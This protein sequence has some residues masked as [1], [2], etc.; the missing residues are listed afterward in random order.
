MNRQRWSLGLI[1][2]GYLAITLAYGAVNPLFEAPD[3]QWH[4]FTAD[5]IASN[6]RLPVVGPDTQQWLGQEAAQPPLYYLL[7]AQLIK[8]IDTAGAADSLWLNPY[9]WI[10][11]A[12]AL[13]NVNRMVHTS[14]E[15]WP[16]QGYALAAHLLRAF[17]T[18]LGLG[19][20]LAIY[21]SGRLVW[22]DDPV[23]PLLATGLVAFLPQFNFIH[24]SV[25]NDTLITFLASAALYQLLRLWQRPN[26]SRQWLALLLLGITVG[27][28]ALTKNAGVVLLIYGL[29]FLLVLAAR[30]GRPRLM[31]QAVL[32]VA[33]P[34]VALAG[35]LWVRNLALYGDP[36]ATN[37]FVAIAGGDRGYTLFQV[38]GE[39]SGLLLSLVGVFGWFNLRPPEWVYGVWAGLGVVAAVGAGSCL[40]WR[41]TAEPPPPAPSNS[42]LSWWARAAR[43]PWMLPLLLAGWVLAVYAGLV[44]FMLQTE[45]AQGRLLFPAILPVALALAW[46]LVGS[47]GCATRGAQGFVRRFWLLPILLALLTTLYCLLFIVRPAYAIPGSVVALP[48]EALPVLPELRDRG[49]GL[50]LLGAAV[51]EDSAEPGDVVWLTLY[52]QAATPPPM[53]TQPIPEQSGLA[54]EAVIEVFGADQ[55]RIGNVHSY[56]G[57]GLY[58]A[59]LWPAGAIIADRFAVQIDPTTPTPVLAR[60]FTRLADGRPGI[61]VATIRV[62]DR[63]GPSPPETTVALLGDSIALAS[64]ALVPETARPGDEV[65][66][67]VQWYVPVGQPAQNYTT[68]IHLGQPDEPPL[69]TADSPPLGGA[70]PTSA[71]RNNEA[72]N[73]RY[74]LSLPADLPAGRYPV[75]IGLYDP[76]TGERLPVVIDG[77][78]QPNNVYL[79]G[80][81][82]VLP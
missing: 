61:E 58:P 7:G 19:T 54:P 82:E 57:R 65:A 46:G 53:P 33:L 41:R 70:Y 29:G 68:L 36:T 20:L 26:G 47:G 78:A 67:V 69:A 35:W 15:A 8:P 38:L 4:F 64:V 63:D 52:W 66:V 80:W 23:K 18:L 50:S 10:G 11:D 34:A 76:A 40:W 9:A 62:A 25:T 39:S 13:A 55:Q 17:S 72:I 44:T 73:D 45:A 31:A 37:Q 74:R 21:G 3:E 32:L 48:E 71:W 42:A 2:L 75:W 81:I 5:Y 79:A 49:Q 56:H 1:L 51:A 43:A 24:A 12:D 16:W 14:A 30:E 27:L 77:A 59:S 22:P 6:A 28:A 60:V